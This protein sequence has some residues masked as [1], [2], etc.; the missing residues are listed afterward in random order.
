MKLTTKLQQKLLNF[1]KGF[2]DKKVLTLL[3][4]GISSAVPYVMIL[5]TLSVWLTEIGFTKTLI[6][7]FAI[8]SA[9]YPFKF[10]WAPYV[11]TWQIPWLGKRL[12][13]RRSWILC[14]QVAV[15]IG[16]ILMGWTNPVE[17]FVPF[18]CF[19]ILVA[20]ASAI[21]DIAVEAYRVETLSVTQLGFG[22][23]MSGFGYRIG[24]L[25]AGAGSLYV[26][27]FFS[28]W[29]M[30]YTIM[31]FLVGLGIMAVWLAEEPLLIDK[32]A[33]TSFNKRSFID[34]AKQ[35]FHQPK[36][37]AMFIF[38]ALYKMNDAMV[39]VMMAPFVEHIGFTKV[40]I[41]NIVKLLGTGMMMFGALSGGFL[42]S[43][44][45][46]FLTLRACIAS[47]TSVSSLFIILSL[48][49]HNYMMLTATMAIEHFVSGMFSSSLIAY[50]CTKCRPGNAGADFAFISSY[51]SFCRVVF[52]FFS[53]WLADHL[54]WTGFFSLILVATIPGIFL[55][56]RF[57]DVFS[58]IPP[59]HDNSIISVLK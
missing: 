1:L 42:M 13:Q 6:G 7:Y 48:L 10:L 30:A 29:T 46:S 8:I 44:F 26:S 15:I 12:G 47:L 55:I 18:I 9:T 49:G 54:G 2:A 41:A 45:G 3:L 52:S 28:S 40:D 5:G 27:S 20:F 35:F 22:A 50:L 17:Q 33:T 39:M 16:L 31:S 34:S 14:S 37:W 53:G 11:D 51:N 43:R 4:F 23:G 56:N 38:I 36:S 19:S 58:T 24:M 59:A 21:Q 25:T 57:K 32:M